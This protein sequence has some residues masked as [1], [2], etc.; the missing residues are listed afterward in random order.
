MQLLVMTLVGCRVETI[1]SVALRNRAFSLRT[2]VLAGCEAAQLCAAA[3]DLRAMVP[4]C[5]RTNN[6][7]A[8]N[9]RFRDRQAMIDSS[10]HAIP[11]DAS[12]VRTVRFQ[13]GVG[14][15][16]R[17]RFYLLYP[18]KAMASKPKKDDTAPATKADVRELH[19]AVMAGM[20]ELRDAISEVR[21]DLK[22]DVSNCRDEVVTLA[23]VMKQESKTYD[24]QFARVLEYIRAEAQ[25]TRGHIDLANVNLEEYCTGLVND[26][27]EAHRDDSRDHERRLRVIERQLRIAT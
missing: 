11:G 5:R 4:C 9:N 21:K 17:S 24:E 7:A 22:A 19:T 1:R 8:S 12:R 26:H 10:S 20:S 18:F 15:H 27:R 23:R 16:L 2:A 14:F 13:S 3:R 6:M 25:E